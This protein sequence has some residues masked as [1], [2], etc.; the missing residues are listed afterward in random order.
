MLWSHFCK[1]SL[2][3]S[4]SECAGYKTIRKKQTGLFMISEDDSYETDFSIDKI[5]PEDL[6]CRRGKRKVPRSHYED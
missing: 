2:V 5:K 1:Y 3:F 4:L 6:A